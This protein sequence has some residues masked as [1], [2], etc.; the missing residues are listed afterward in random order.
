MKKITYLLTL[1]TL[2]CNLTLAQWEWQYSHG[3]PLLD[4]D[5]INTQT[6]WACGDWGQILK[7]T[8]GGLNWIAQNSGSVNRLEG[9]DAVDE[10]ILYCV[11]WFQT[12][13]KST[14]GGSNWIAIRNGTTN[15]VPSFFKCFFLN[16]DTGWM[17]RNGWILRTTNGGNNFDSSYVNIGYPRDIYFKNATTGVLCGNGA[18]VARSTDGGVVW[19]QVHLPLLTGAPNL[20]R[21]SFVGDYGWTIGEASESGLGKLVFKT[22]N[23]GISWDSIARVPYPETEL[24]YS[25]C[26]TSQSTGYCGGT[27]GYIYKTTNGGFNWYRQVFPG[28]SFRNDFWFA[29]DSLGWSVGGGGAIYKTTNGGTY[30]SLELISNEIPLKHSIEKIYPNP[31]NPET[32]IIFEVAYE[33]EIKI[34]IYDITG[35][36][37]ASIIQNKFSPGRYNIKFNAGSLSSGVYFCKLSSLQVSITKTIMLVK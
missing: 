33:D 32:N 22:T 16:A 23:F 2:S 20:Y 28:T 19:N 10:N 6:G 3:S 13:L 7:T 35:R 25:V 36:E 8:N 30:V 5:F 37:V 18:F 31:F 29:N 34:T 9:I 17:L 1:L 21:I 4:V 12:I 27:T 15:N 26:F 14:N 11:G 24:N